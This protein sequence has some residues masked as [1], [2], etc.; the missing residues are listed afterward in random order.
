MDLGVAG[1][2]GDTMIMPVRVL[3]RTD[4]TTYDFIQGCAGPLV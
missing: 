2:G 4:G 1:I 3:G